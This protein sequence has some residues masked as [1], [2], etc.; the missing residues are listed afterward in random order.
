MKR[1]R[2]QLIIVIAALAAIGLLLLSQQPGGQQIMIIPEPVKGGTYS[3]ALIGSPARFNPTLDYVNSVDRDVDRLIFSGLIKFDDR[4]TPQADLAESWGISKDGTSYNFA[5]RKNA[6]W[7]DGQPVTSDDV[8]FTVELLRHPDYPVSD[9]LRGMW[10]TIEIKRLDDKNLQFRL[11]EPFSPFLDFLTFGVLPKHLLGSMTPKEIV[12]ASFNLAPIGSGPYRFTRLITETGADGKV[13]ISG[14]E[15]TAFDKYYSH[16]PYIDQFVFRFYPDAASTLVA[17]RERQVQGIG[18]ITQDI[19]A[20]ALAEGRLNLYTS[21]LPRQ[22]LVLLNLNNPEVPFFQTAEVR[23]AMM[24]GINRQKII[25]KLLNGQAI[26]ATGPIFPGTWAYFDGIQPINYDTDKGISI[27][28]KAGYTIPASGSTRAKENQ[29]LAFDM[30]YVDDP[31]NKAVAESIQQNWADMQVTVTLKPVKAEELLPNYLEPRRYQAALVQL[32]L[33]RSPDPDPYPFW[34]Q[35]QATG[36]QN[37]SQWEDRQSSEY[38]EQ[39]RVTIDPEERARLYRNFQVRFAS[40]LPA[41]PLYYQVYTYGV[42]AEVQG[43]RLG[44]LFDPSDRFSMAADWFL[45]S[46]GK[47]AATIAPQ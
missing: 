19:L 17:F 42:D 9:D 32:D 18:K 14:V 39:A 13:Q 5:L 24:M 46:K 41:L 37:Y 1:L 11:P 43:V 2:W 36:G 12:D 29:A 16:Q 7:H 30:I 38:L 10:N 35:A 34:H 25:D 6:V 21:R 8:L 15:L 28:K 40:E 47:V 4:G 33:T 20:Q 26:M 31:L 22:T 45:I 27:L 3:E 44:P 23:Q